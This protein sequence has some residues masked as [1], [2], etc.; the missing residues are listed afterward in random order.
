MNLKNKGIDMIINLKQIF[1][2]IIIFIKY[3]LVAIFIAII[4]FLSMSFLD[5][6]IADGITK[7]KILMLELGMSEKKIIKILGKPLKKINYEKD[8]KGINT[9]IYIYATSSLEIN[10]ALDNGKLERVELE[11]HDVSFYLCSNDVCPKIIS[12]FLWKY[13][14]PND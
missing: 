1:K 6:E 5:T 13:L 4:I 14:I 3:I 11:F 7:E 9:T 8:Y 12:P 2:K 10:I